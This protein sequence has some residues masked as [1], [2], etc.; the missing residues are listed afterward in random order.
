MD[1]Q[2]LVRLLRFARNDNMGILQRFQFLCLGLALTVS[3]NASLRVTS[4]SASDFECINIC[5][6]LGLPLRFC[7][8]MNGYNNII[9][10]RQPQ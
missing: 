9:R 10:Y 6:Y 5:Y 3:A 7:N 2:R 4:C 1:Y 8:E